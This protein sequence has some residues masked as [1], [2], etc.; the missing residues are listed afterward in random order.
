MTL[1]ILGL[2]KASPLHFPKSRY[3]KKGS[4][5]GMA[6]RAPFLWT[7]LYLKSMETSSTK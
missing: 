1:G 5:G 2:G 3:R 7:H 4:G 6:A